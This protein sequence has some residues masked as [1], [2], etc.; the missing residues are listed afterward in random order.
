[1]AEY[2]VLKKVVCP[3]CNGLGVVFVENEECGNLFEYEYGL[4]REIPCDMCNGTGVVKEEVP[5]QEVLN[6]FFGEGKFAG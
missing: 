5:F 4:E 6:E 3:K 1:M 2:Y